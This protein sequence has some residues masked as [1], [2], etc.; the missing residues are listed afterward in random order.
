MSSNS[1][2]SEQADHHHD[3]GDAVRMEQVEGVAE[4]A[5]VGVDADGGGPS[6][7]S[8]RRPVVE[9]RIAHQTAEARERQHHQREHS[10]GPN[11][12]AQLARIGAEGNDAD[13]K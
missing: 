8:V 6:G 7:R 4:A 11:A 13:R 3:E 9:Q 5:T 2:D 12:S 10:A 1:L